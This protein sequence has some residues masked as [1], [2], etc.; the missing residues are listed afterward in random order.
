VVGGELA[1]FEWTRLLLWRELA[2]FENALKAPL[3]KRM[4][5]HSVVEAQKLWQ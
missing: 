4:S 5:M 3:Y 2:I 1:I